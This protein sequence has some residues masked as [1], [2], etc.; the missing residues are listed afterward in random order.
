MM[1]NPRRAEMNVEKRK[2]AL[3]KIR[4]KY[5]DVNSEIRFMAIT[6]S[7]PKPLILRADLIMGFYLILI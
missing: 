3:A 4:K 7:E 6:V 2:L 5:P 1:T